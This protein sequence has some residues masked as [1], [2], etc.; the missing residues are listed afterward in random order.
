M[1][2]SQ[3]VEG[4]LE[5]GHRRRRAAASLARR[6]LAKLEPR[7]ASLREAYAADA[8]FVARAGMAGRH[9]AGPRGAS[10]SPTAPAPLSFSAPADRASAARPSRSLAAGAF[11]ATTAW[12]RAR[13]AHA[14]LRQ[15]RCPYARACSFRPRPQDHALRGDLEVGRHARDAGASDRRHRRRA[16]G[17]S[18]RPHPRAVPRPHRACGAR[19]RPTACARCASVSPFRR[20]TTIPISAAG[21]PA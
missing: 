6:D 20:S 21:S 16:P 2:L 7:L 8:P 4:C 17:R 1:P 9:R 14:L 12:Q 13:A 19:A 18:R 11:P 10:G 3:S 5:A 15:S